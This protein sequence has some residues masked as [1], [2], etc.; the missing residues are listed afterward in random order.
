MRH[1]LLKITLLIA[2]LGGLA[3]PVFA[4]PPPRVTV[5]DSTATGSCLTFP[6]LNKIYDVWNNAQSQ[7]EQQYTDDRAAY[8]FSERGDR[9]VRLYSNTLA[10]LNA[11][12]PPGIVGRLA[13]VTDGI[14]GIW[15]DTGMA[16]V[17][18]TGYADVRDFG[19]KGDGVTDDTTAIQAAI[20]GIPLYSGATP[21]IGTGGWTVYLNSGGVYL[22]SD[23]LKP[24]VRRIA[25]TSESPVN[26]AA[27]TTLK[28]TNANKDIIDY[29]TG[30]ADTLS[31]SNI[32]FW[33]A[34]SGTGIG[35]GITIGSAG[36][37]VYDSIIRDNWFVNIPNAA[38]YLKNAADY[39]I[40]GNG[41]EISKYGVYIEG[42]PANT[43]ENTI[44]GNT[45]YGL[46]EAGVFVG[47]GD[48]LNIIGNQFGFNGGTHDNTRGAIVLRKSGTPAI[49]STLISANQFKANTNDIILDGVAGSSL[50]GNSGVL[51]TSIVGNQSDRVYRRFVLCD[52]ANGTRLIDNT[53]T[54]PDQDFGDYNAFDI[55]T[56]SD[57]TILFGNSVSGV[58]SNLPGYGLS[59]GASTTNTTIGSNLFTGSLGA[60]SIA[61]GATLLNPTNTRFSAGGTALV[62]GDVAL[63]AGW[64][65]TASVSAI[66]GTDQRF[67]LTITSAGTGQ[68]ANPT[69]T[70]TWKDGSWGTAPFIICQ[71]TTGSQPTVGARVTSRSATAFT[72]TWDGTPIAA[73]TYSFVCQSMG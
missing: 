21:A 17:S 15:K 46:T 35:N 72:M 66:S 65:T 47:G 40:V 31:V 69:A 5:R 29:S 8:Q 57:G 3:A 28:Q 9:P 56:T 22:L 33:G 6:C 42:L 54:S 71:R 62:A 51:E 25:F 64:G 10:A 59:L 30:H 49:R 12:Y 7:S 38:I 14:R 27:G 1:L 60:V 50:S 58:A 73:E 53:I 61:A 39:K 52:D 44:A 16:W 11:A 55:T 67:E 23:S 70:I 18:V 34:G 63:S 24:G 43:D 4:A 20:D 41:L 26:G 37:T 48:N 19:A 2:M 32:V 13:R 45:L 68:G 36:G